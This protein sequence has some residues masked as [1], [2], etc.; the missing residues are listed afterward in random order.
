MPRG[1]WRVQ[2][3][4]FKDCEPAFITQ[5]VI[6]LRLAVF[7]PGEVIFR[8]GDVGHE[9]YFITKVPLRPRRGAARRMTAW[10]ARMHAC[11]HARFHA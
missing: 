11:V 10:H 8:I 3:P 5:L 9:M 7:L 1:A 4:L 6:R 2:V